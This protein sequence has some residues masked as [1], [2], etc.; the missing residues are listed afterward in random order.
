[1]SRSVVPPRVVMLLV[2]AAASWGVGTVISK[3]AVA[4]DPAPRPAR[5][6]AGDERRRPVGR[7][8]RRARARHVADPDHRLGH[9]A[10]ER[11]GLLNPGAAYALSLIGLSQT[12][13]SLSVLLW[14]VEPVLI[15][16]LAWRWL[17]ER[18]ASRL[19]ALSIAAAGGMVLVVWAPGVGGQAFGIAVTLA[20][21]GCCARSTRS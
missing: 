1:M 4:R 6:P 13:A 21:V 20:G 15:L 9:A 17:G 19:A 2:L 14:A 18:V 16:G 10:I 7:H 12:S 11:L 3:R 5:R 8:A